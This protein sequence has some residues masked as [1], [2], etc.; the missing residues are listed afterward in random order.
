MAFTVDYDAARQGFSLIEPGDYECVIMEVVPVTAKSGTQG[1]K[2]TIKLRDDVAQKSAGRDFEQTMWTKKDTGQLPN[3]MLNAMAKA[4]GLPNGKQYGSAL[5]L[6]GD[7]VFK[8]FLGEI[9]IEEQEY[10]VDKK[11]W[12]SNRIVKWHET[13]YPNLNMLKPGY[14]EI[15]SNDVPF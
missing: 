5:E 12:R 10:G 2:F 1:F 7:M 15:D 11:I 3:G 9:I 4:I 14:S 6:F 8:P 13:K